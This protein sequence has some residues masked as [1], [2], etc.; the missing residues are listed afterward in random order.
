M[1]NYNA[2]ATP[3]EIGAKLKKETTDKF[4][5]VT[6]YKQIIGSLKYLCNT[7]PYIS[8]SVGLLS[9]FMEKP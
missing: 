4:V 5:S 8:Q 2:A 9:R 1:R 3:L 7:R 6:L